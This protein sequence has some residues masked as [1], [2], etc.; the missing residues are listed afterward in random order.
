M[1]EEYADIRIRINPWDEARKSYPVEAA[2]DDGSQYLG[3]E[4]RIDMQKLLSA[5]LDSQSYGMELF[6]ALF[7][8]KIRRAYDKVTGRAEAEAEGR[9]RVRLWIDD[10]ASEL[11]ALPW[12]RLYH[13]HKGIE[14]PLTTSALTPFSRFTGL[15]I[16]ESQPVRERP[17]RVLAAI[18]NPQELPTGLAPI[19][20]EEEMEN[21]RQTLG[22]LR[23][24]RLIQVTLMPGRTGLSARLRAALEGEGYRIQDGPTSLENLVR[25]IPGCHVLHFLGHGHFRRTGTGD[26][27]AAALHLENAQGGWKAA[28]DAELVSKITNLDPLPRLVFLSACE[29]AKRHAEAENPLVGI[30]PKLVKAGVPAVIAMQDTVPMEVARQLT[31]DFYQRLLE[32]GFVDRA[33]NEARLLLFDNKQVDWAVPVLFMRLKDGRLLASQ[34]L[35]Q[36]G[37]VI[38]DGLIE[39]YTRLFA[40]R[41]AAITELEQFMADPSGGYLL[42]KAGAGLG[43]TALMASLVACHREGLAYHFFS[44]RVS[45]S[46]QETVFLHNILEQMGPWYGLTDPPAGQPEDMRKRYD[47]LLGRNPQGIHTLVLDGL[48]E[49]TGWDLSRYLARRLPSG[50]HF[51]L[52]VR[53]TGCDPVEDFALPPDQVRSMPLVGL[54]RDGVEAVLRAAGGGALQFAE[55]D[56][57]LDQVLRVTAYDA[58]RPELGADTFFVRF[59]AEDAAAGKVKPAEL[60]KMP[61]Q[62]E[63]YLDRWWRTLKAEFGEEGDRKKRQQAL[64]DLAGTLT[65][66]LGPIGRLDLEAINPSLVSEIEQDFVETVVQAVRRIVV[67]DPRGDH[68][69]LHPRLRHYLRRKLKI[70][71]YVQG[72]LKHCAQWNTHRSRYALTHYAAHLAEAAAAADQPE[73]HRQTEALIEL[74]T[75]RRFHDAY[76]AEIKDL[77]GLQTDLQRGLAAVARDES[78]AALPLLVAGALSLVRFR[79]ERLRPE[80]I[81]ELA[82]QGDVVAAE[83]MLELFEMDRKWQQVA[84][85]EIAW[86][87][88]TAPSEDAREQAN[89]LRVK[90]TAGLQGI[91]A[92]DQR[93]MLLSWILSD[94]EGAP[95]PRTQGY[96]PNPPHP[97]GLR[98]MLDTAAGI[99]SEADVSP[100]MLN[101]VIRGLKWEMLVA[102]NEAAGRG[103]ELS[104]DMFFAHYIGPELVAFALADPPAGAH[105]LK[106]YLG[107][108]SAYNYATY[109]FGSL[110][111]LL[112]PMLQHSEPGWIR[113]NVAALLCSALAGGSG[114]FEEGLPL[115]VLALRA[116]AGEAQAAGELATCVAA[117]RQEAEELG[118]GRTRGDTWGRYKR[119]FATLAQL[120]TLTGVDV[121]LSGR[122]LLNEAVWMH[123][124]F[125]GYQAPACLMLAEAVRTCHPAEE[126]DWISRCLETAQRAAHNIQEGTF[127]ARTTARVNAMRSRWWL[128]GLDLRREIAAL[129]SHPGCER[130]AA[131]H[132]TDHDYLGRGGPPRSFPLPD[133]VRNAN[134]LAKLADA[135]QRG[136][137]EFLRLNRGWEPEQPIPAGTPIHVPDPGLAPLLAARL[138]TEALIAKGLSAA[139]RVALIRSLVPVAAANPTALDTVLARL[140]LAERPTDAA[141]LTRLAELAPMP[142]DTHPDNLQGELTVVPP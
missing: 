62:M 94:L 33:L 74:V 40:G 71:R 119:L 23:R 10:G 103:D 98:A 105:Y 25:V 65:A 48:D 84:L 20:V 66:A 8:G 27:A 77:R 99:S 117:F 63:A 129:Q 96:L 134:T 126:D 55:D 44:P 15:E 7:A 9:V 89:A 139:E 104:E 95:R 140:L 116:G 45:E 36:P 18:A 4:L 128:P 86:L 111:A 124:G 122:D 68:T 73:R 85:L 60:T 101:P 88:G 131:L 67:R 137:P 29:S 83:R 109:R 142:K 90:A 82:S 54:T 106:E 115:T 125:A 92:S 136:L 64:V 49:V 28:T 22:G 42:M 32:H 56:G 108:H 24:S 1:A 30:G 41:E 2:L 110:W 81:F 138:A 31:A 135:Y 78:P 120:Q 112:R 121:S 97:S 72:L 6:D 35:E 5:Q 127:C 21:L 123:Y 80:L 52:T 79:Q 76:L 75:D 59:L 16:A 37:C 47:V 118:P 102:G 50:L 93:Q 61:S 34:A 141:I 107:V 39:E 70:D 12:E 53:D 58:N 26:E 46:L 114:E 130:F 43:K 69:L 51:I 14:V 19:D 57:L 13:I 133:R 132:Y 38:F 17:I 100:E 87:G 11:H 3:G 91:P 113:N